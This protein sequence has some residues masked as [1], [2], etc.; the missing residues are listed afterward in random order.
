MPEHDPGT[1]PHHEHPQPPS[2]PAGAPERGGGEPSSWELWAV[3]RGPFLMYVGREHEGAFLAVGQRMFYAL[4]Q[5]PP[6]WSESVVRAEARAAARDLRFLEQ[7]LGFIGESRF[8]S[9][10]DRPDS[11]LSERAERW[12]VR[13]AE[14]AAEVEAA[15]EEERRAK[16]DRD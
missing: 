16:P 10:L 13:V 15:L 12:A 2:D 4:L 1:E 5:E 3:F 11:R 7:Y 6:D 14:L 9:E 8:E